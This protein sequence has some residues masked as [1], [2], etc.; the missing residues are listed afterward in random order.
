MKHGDTVFLDLLQ[1]LSSVECGEGCETAIDGNVVGG[2]EVGA[3][4]VVQ[5]CLK[6]LPSR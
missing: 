1:Q 5:R 2:H 6:E 3:L 4:A